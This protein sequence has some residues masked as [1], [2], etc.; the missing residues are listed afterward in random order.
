MGANLLNKSLDIKNHQGYNS[1]CP[2]VAY[3]SYIFRGGTA[4][5]EA[6]KMLLD[7]FPRLKFNVIQDAGH[8][9]HSEQPVKFTEILCDFIKSVE[10]GKS[11]RNWRPSLSAQADLCGGVSDGWY[12][13]PFKEPLTS[14]TT[15]QGTQPIER[16]MSAFSSLL[17]YCAKIT[18][19]H[20]VHVILFCWY[21]IRTK[22][23]ICWSSSLINITS[24]TQ[25]GIQ[26]NHVI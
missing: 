2:Y 16:L 22:I 11:W 19:H 26:Q 12:Q 9:V 6:S 20:Q 15:K 7:Y 24:P 3:V 21:Y 14:P 10:E 4:E 23:T 17:L 8:W 13:P 5:E 18:E 1:A 25:T